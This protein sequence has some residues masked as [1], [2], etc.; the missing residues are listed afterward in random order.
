MDTATEIDIDKV[1][2]QLNVM[3]GN[4]KQAIQFLLV[5]HGA[6]IGA[7]V[8]ALKDYATV[9]ALKGIGMFIT[10]FCSGFMLAMCAYIA[11]MIFD[12]SVVYSMFKPVEIKHRDFRLGLWLVSAS[13]LCLGAALVLLGG[14]LSY[15]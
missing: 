12:N 5:A 13:S 8:A 10:I 6:G 9:P 2:Q 3:V 11:L 4:I 7:C 1:R 15:L 14:R